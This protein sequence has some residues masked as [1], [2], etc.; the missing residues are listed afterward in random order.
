MAKHSQSSQTDAEVGADSEPPRQ[1]LSSQD[2]YG[3]GELADELGIS[4]RAVRFY[5]TKGLLKPRR[6]GANRVYDRRDRARLKL[7]LRGK[8]LGFSL[9]E[10]SEYLDLYE[11]DP[12]QKLQTRHLLTKVEQAIED[13]RRK[14]AD[15]DS[16]I[17]E[18]AVIRAQCL[19]QL[20]SEE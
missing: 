9:Q 6:V 1:D 4:Q 15:I 8:R 10:I 2:L 3:I 5:E 12:E 18:L 14:R 16:T 13:L 7:I 17:D 20:E 19:N 11:R